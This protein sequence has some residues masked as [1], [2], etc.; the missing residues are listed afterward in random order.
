M[1]FRPP[2]HHK[3]LE[4]FSEHWAAIGE[5]LGERLAGHARP[6]EVLGR[7]A[8]VFGRRAG[9]RFAIHP[10]EGWDGTAD[11]APSEWT[12]R[13]WEN[14]G[15][16][17]ADLIWGG[18]AFA[19]HPDGRA[20]PNQLFLRAGDASLNDLRELRASLKRGRE[21]AGLDPQRHPVLDERFGVSDD[22]LLSDAELSGLRERYLRAAELAAEAGFDFV[23]IKACHGY[24][25][26]ELLAARHR[27]GPYG[28]ELESRWRLLE[29]VLTGVRERC[30]ELGLGVRLSA[31]DTFPHDKGPDGLGAPVGIEE[32]RP[33]THAFGVDAEQPLNFDLEE[34]RSL[35]AHLV[36]LGV[37][38]L[39]VTAGSPYYCPH[40]L[41][42]AAYPPSDGYKPHEDPLLNVG[43][44]IAL[45]R[46]L[47][48]SFPE[49]PLVG[50]GYSY[51]Q[52]WLPSVG[53]HEVAG[54]HVDFVGIGRMVLSYPEF[55]LDVLRGEQL[56]RKR[57]C[58][59]FSDCTTAPRKGKLSGCYPLDP[60]YR[61]LPEA[62]EIAAI[63][64]AAAQ[65]ADQ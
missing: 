7:D 49:L 3:S 52:E 62:K 43:R 33:Y 8:E 35:I 6:Q 23:D 29:E 31:A 65:G 14:F 10:M 61:A 47:K 45:T 59:T 1:D 58:R 50:S 13:R 24:L 40:L 25:M 21:R 15:A 34:P 51:L 46:A 41:R 26:H 18:E 20:N 55:P 38:A 12:L 11:G 22:A 37:G 9:N 44:H 19:V 32:H 28:G 60:T 16:S 39:N 57:I 27:P 2:S 36:D 54:G 63:R 64:R 4:A 56:Q 48:S 17:G 30:P 42:P 53:A 5:Q